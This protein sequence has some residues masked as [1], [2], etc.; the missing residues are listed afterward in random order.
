MRNIPTNDNVWRY[1]G[2]TEAKSFLYEIVAN[3]ISGLDV[4][5]WDYLI[6][7]ASYF[8]I[9]RIFDPDRIMNYAKVIKTG[10]N[11]RKHICIRDKEAEGI[12]E[13]F[14]DRARMHKNG[15]QH[16]VTK[17]IGAMMLDIFFNADQHIQIKGR[18]GKKY[19][20]SEA[21]EDIVAHEKLTD[22]IFLRIKD[23]DSEDP[24][25]KTAQNLIQRIMKRDFY[26]SLATINITKDHPFQNK[27][28]KDLEVELQNLI[29]KEAKHLKPQEL[30]VIQSKVSMGMGT[31]NPIHNVTFYN[32]EG[33][34]V[35]DVNALNISQ[36]LPDFLNFKTFNIVC[37]STDKLAL[38]EAVTLIQKVMPRIEKEKNGH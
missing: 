28:P 38:K 31:R 37:K 22:E 8:N 4:D 21:C 6:R 34:V 12:M 24:E 36:Y 23:A 15:Y 16:R 7:D 13:M 35:E 26:K 3:K 9:G 10:E 17:L 11:E 5:K 30:I 18:N 1:R 33:D 20:M 29:Q 19:S 27:N 32:K 14:I 25:M 2:R